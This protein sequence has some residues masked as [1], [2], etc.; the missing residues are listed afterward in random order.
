MLS[1]ATLRQNFKREK[2]QHRLRGESSINTN[3]T[4]YAGTLPVYLFLHSSCLVGELYQLHTPI[5]CYLPGSKNAT[6][7]S[8]SLSPFSFF[9]IAG[10]YLLPSPLT[11]T[12][13]ITLSRKCSF[14]LLSTLFK[15]LFQFFCEFTVVRWSV[16]WRD[17]CIHVYCRLV[18]FSSM[19]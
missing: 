4:K 19:S 8:V 2:Q 17:M 5:G 15:E 14:S 18:S 11:P 3:L 9:P 10:G 12:F 6:C 7:S 1:L 16:S 13:D